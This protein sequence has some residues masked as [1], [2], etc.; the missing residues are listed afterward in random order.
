MQVFHDVTP[1]SEPWHFLFTEEE[2]QLIMNGLFCSNF[3]SNDFTKVLNDLYQNVNTLGL[4][5]KFRDGS[6]P[7]PFK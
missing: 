6:S 1:S 5:S 2:I 3:H 7:C 4:F